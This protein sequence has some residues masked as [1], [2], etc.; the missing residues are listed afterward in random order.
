MNYSSPVLTNRFY[1][2]SVGICFG[3]NTLLKQIHMCKDNQIFRNKKNRKGNG[4]SCKN[5]DRLYRYCEFFKKPTMPQM[6]IYGI[7]YQLICYKD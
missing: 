1:L 2:Y 7:A 4:K 6:P 3:K 5:K